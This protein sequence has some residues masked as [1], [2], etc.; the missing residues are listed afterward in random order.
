MIKKILALA[1][2]VFVLGWLSNMLFVSLGAVSAQPYLPAQVSGNTELAS[3][4][5]ITTVTLEREPAQASGNTELAAAKAT[6]D[7]I[8]PVVA[9]DRE[10]PSP[11]DRFQIQDVHVTDN[12]VIIDGIKGRSF[13]TAIFT[14]TNSMDP[15]LDA[16]SQAIQ[17]VPLRAEEI[18]LGDVISY[19]S[20][21]YGVIIHR[22][23][24][25][26]NDSQGWYA[27]V[28][29]DNNPIADPVKVRFSM[30]KRVLV[31]VLY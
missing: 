28:K 23:I 13:E 8:A 14:D 2:A 7:A 29:G 3:A 18:K 9:S 31:G 17:I 5:K 26:G 19:D 4:E 21:A 15:V 20:G 10:K 30:I 1:M 27:I 22:V 24:Q 16:G 12:Q 11:A 25:I 6:A